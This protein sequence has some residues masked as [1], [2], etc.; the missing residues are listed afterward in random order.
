MHIITMHKNVI[1]NFKLLMR[2]LKEKYSVYVNN[3]PVSGFVWLPGIKELS[4]R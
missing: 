4:K 3:E 1:A 2:T